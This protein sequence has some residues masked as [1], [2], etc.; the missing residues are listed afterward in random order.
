MLVATKNVT[1]MGKI[2]RMDQVRNIITTYLD[3]R[4]IKGTARR[5][6]IS[7]NTVRQYLTKAKTYHPDLSM[8]LKLNEDE[9]HKVIY[10]QVEKEFTEREAV[11]DSL[12]D[13]WIEELPRV[14]V[15]RQLLWE[16]YLEDYPQGYKYSQ[17]CERLKRVIASKGVTIAMDHPPGECMQLDFAGKTMSW[18]DIKSGEVHCCQVLV[19]VMPHSQHSFAIALPSQKLPDFL[20]GINQALLFFGKL[21]KVIL[22]D[23][24]KSFVTKANRYEPDFN[25][26]CVQLATHYQL[27]LKAARSRK[28]CDKASV[29]NMV[30][31]VYTRIYAPLR[32]RVFH[33][34]EEIN[35]AISGQLIIHNQ[36]NYQKKTG[37]RQQIYNDVELP[38]MR[39]LPNETFEVKHSTKAKVQKNYHVFLGE[40]KNYYSVPY[41]YVGKQSLII[42]TR[43]IV[44][45]YI[46]NQRVAIHKRLY[47]SGGY[48]YAT[49]K[50]HMPRSHQEWRESSG[51]KAADFISWAKNIGPCCE[52]AIGCILKSKIHE[53]QS[54]RSCQ[55]VQSLARRFTAQRLEAACKRCQSAQ[56][57][58]YKML[59]NIL[60]SNL[61]QQTEQA[62]SVCLPTHQ[63]VRGP[64][65]YQ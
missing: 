40:E 16:E 30:K 51:Q 10:E 5:L 34:M 49:Q 43:K 20:E 33:S 2:K 4:S 6:Q 59:E 25:E 41:K 9:L 27:D 39:D 54:Y 53:P 65:A 36:K 60:K 38:V 61:D 7:K 35:E 47:D 23:N 8:V 19:A 56:K 45:V 48:V 13:Y 1:I 62:S 42:Y 44:E 57:A 11:F 18:V 3:I 29:E 52:W 55:G 14:G 12:V 24:L 58:N 17:F 64:E 22:S 26:L 37:F 15:T 21:P 28:P 50:N 32:N 31:T 63:N 46:D